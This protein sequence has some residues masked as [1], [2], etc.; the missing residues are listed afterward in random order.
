MQF[1]LETERLILRRFA[2]YDVDNLVALDSDPEVM[3]FINGGVP[4]SREVVQHRI[5]PGFLRSYDRNPGFGAWAAI[6]R[7]SGDFI[8]WLSLRPAEGGT[9]DNVALG[10]RLRRAAWGK[11]Y[12]TEGARAVIRKAFAELGVR[13]VFA[14]TYEHNLASRRVMEKAGLTL[15]RRYR[16]TPADLAATNTFDGATSQDVWEG[17]EVE[18]ALLRVDWQRQAGQDGGVGAH[19]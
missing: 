5:L 14:T 7:A 4:T 12:A 16:L 2:A 1:Y 19:A 15:V 10:Y 8:G 18:Y 17:D 13:R 9:P 6:E 3:R 11:G